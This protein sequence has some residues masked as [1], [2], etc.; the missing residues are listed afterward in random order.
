MRQIDNYIKSSHIISLNEKYSLKDKFQIFINKVYFGDNWMTNAEYVNKL[1]KFVNEHS[2]GKVGIVIKK[3][4]D[5]MKSLGDC[6]N[7][8]ENTLKGH[9]D[10]SVTLKNALETGTWFGDIELTDDTPF[11]CYYN[12][13]KSDKYV[14]EPFSMCFMSQ[15]TK[16]GYRDLV[17]QLILE[18]D[19]LDPENPKTF[20]YEIVHER[21]PQ[22]LDWDAWE[23]EEKKKSEEQKRKEQENVE[24]RIK[25]IED[26]LEQ[27]KKSI[28]KE[29]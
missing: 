9:Y 10:K 1:K 23:A 15:R 3:Y 11:I 29:D 22:T 24:K 25:E 2:D 20:G 21:I 16:D 4:K 18:P 8:N 12:K 14:I 26:E 17:G 6:L 5:I 19:E 27:L 7:I 13:D 28:N